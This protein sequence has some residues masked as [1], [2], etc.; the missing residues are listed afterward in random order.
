[1]R[2]QIPIERWTVCQLVPCRQ[3]L[4]VFWI[5]RDAEIQLGDGNDE[6]V[7]RFSMLQNLMAGGSLIILNVSRTT[8]IILLVHH[9]HVLLARRI[10]KS[11]EIPFVYLIKALDF[12][13]LAIIALIIEGQILGLK[14]SIYEISVRILIFT[15]EI[16]RQSLRLIFRAILALERCFGE[17]RL[18]VAAHA[19][20]SDYPLAICDFS[21]F[22]FHA[23]IIALNST[24]FP[25][26][27]E[28]CCG[29]T[30]GR[31]LWCVR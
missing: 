5:T 13:G 19:L 11:L 22:I 27:I 30:S 10:L 2:N 26:L 18:T 1:M 24:A 6:L 31:W 7:E 29:S 4:F 16:L 12:F 17:W 9:I 28:R 25:G 23:V 3:L 15:L 20:L 21:L 14:R 8:R